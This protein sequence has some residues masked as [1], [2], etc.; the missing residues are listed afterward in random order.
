MT[1]SPATSVS[2]ASRSALIPATG[3]GP[4]LHDLPLGDPGPGQV[5]VRMRAAAL[6]FADLLMRKGTYQ[7]TPPTP[8]TPGLE[9]AGEVEAAGPGTDLRPGT[10]VAVWL[11]GCLT[12]CGNF[13]AADCLPLPDAM[14][15]EDAAGFQIAYGTS[16][17]ALTLR[18]GLQAGETLAVLGA[19]GGVG[20]TAVEIGAALGARVIAVARG[21]E[22]CAIAR[23][24]G[25][26][27]VLD[28]DET[29]DLR[30]ALRA[31]GGVDVVYDPV[32]DAAGLAAFG[33][34]KP[35]GRF[36][37]IGFAGGKTPALPLNHALVK[38][39]TIHGIHWAAYRDLDHAAL[40]SSLT[41]LFALYEQGRLHPHN[42][43]ILPLDRLAE[44]YDALSERRS[45]G[46]VIITL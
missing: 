25:A 41:A 14:P 33:G 16:H 30:A 17:L 13:D 29:P 2:V 32:G 37:V 42:G 36:L 34:L 9:G 45:V 35:G 12:Q 40:R 21:A 5:R 20:L 26:H 6:N 31:F 28:S 24:A 18:A 44:G 43:L 15:Y 27:E 19:A 4:I 11:Q 10:R 38:N 3:E 22:K 39:I 7:D 23:A 8:F 46:K 1:E